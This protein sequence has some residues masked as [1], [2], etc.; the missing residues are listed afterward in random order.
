MINNRIMNIK[1]SILLFFGWSILCAQPKI[2]LDTFA[3]GYPKPVGIE[4]DG[5]TSR[6]FVLD[7][8]GRIFVLD[9]LGNKLDTFLDIRN[10]VQY[11]NNG[12]QGLLGL[13]FHPDYRNNGYFYVYH[14]I[15]NTTN[16]AV[17]RYKVTSNPNRA[18]IDS[19]KLVIAIPH[20]LFN[21]HNGGCIKFGKDGFLYIGIGDG[22]SGNDPNNNAQNK[23]TLLGKLLRLDVNNFTVAYTV[24]STNP[25]VGQPNVKTEIWAL[26]LRNPWRFSFD[27]N[28]GDLWL[29]DVGQNNI[30]EVNFQPASN[31]GGDNYGWRCYEGNSAFNTTGCGASSN[32]KFP[33]FTYPHTS[34]NG[35]FSITGGYIYQGNQYKYLKDYYLFTDYVS[36]NFWVS[37]RNSSTFSTTLLS[38]PKQ[39][40]IS[41]FGEDIKGELYACNLNNGTIYKIRELCE[42]F[43]ITL[44]PKNLTCYNSLD[45]RIDVLPSGNNGT[46][47]YSWSNG[48]TGNNQLNLSDGKYVVTAT[49]AIGCS[50]KDSIILSKPDT[51]I[52]QSQ[53]QHP[54]CENI[55]SGSIILFV[56]GGTGGTY[57]YQWNDG[58]TSNVI[59]FLSAGNYAVTV[60]DSNQCSNSAS[61]TLYNIDTLE[62]PIITYGSDFL[63]TTAG[64]QS[65]RWIKNGIELL[66]SNKDTIHPNLTENAYYIVEVTDWNGCKALS[67]T[68]LHIWFQSHPKNSMVDKF[69]VYPNPVKGKL[70]IDISFIQNLPITIQLSNAV[71]QIVMQQKVEGK[72]IQTS[73]L[74]STLAS[75]LYQ[76]SILLNNKI[77]ATQTFYKE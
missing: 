49:D 11:I 48:N 38:S 65:Y 9:S 26:G 76:I 29:A 64:Y 61:F 46:V 75:G 39:T 25:F 24:P 6:L 4:N 41:S 42:Q 77:T 59:Q 57:R 33:F 66:G 12:E 10:S 23:N 22:G 14:T 53:I 30:E 15:K 7:Q 67:D 56:T 50:V 18:N 40:N 13:A 52:I 58:A 74:T 45:G 28:S 20:P 17:Y 69:T 72:H 1:L 8:T 31:T 63:Q 43:K 71:G 32:Y 51:I 47:S 54:R 68:F 36:G 16:N 44:V 2:K 35:G 62:K 60:I 27:R 3:L 55:Q 37:K 21:N 34:S 73:F 5:Y 70:N 19:Q